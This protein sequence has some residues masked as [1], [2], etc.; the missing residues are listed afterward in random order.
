MNY[1]AEEEVMR[2]LS[3]SQMEDRMELLPQEHGCKPESSLI[4]Q[5]VTAKIGFK[6]QR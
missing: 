3:I 4:A 5:V 2:I 1:V 6:V